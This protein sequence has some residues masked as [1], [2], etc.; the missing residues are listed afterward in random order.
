MEFDK[1]DVDIDYEIYLPR[2]A[3]IEVSNDFGDIIITDWNGKLE[4]LLRHGD[5]KI[6]EPVKS[7]KLN[8]SFGNINA[9]KIQAGTVDLKNGKLKV[10]EIE[11]LRLQSSGSELTLESVGFL[12]IKSIK[13]KCTSI[14]L[15]E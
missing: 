1:S 3:S 6:T 15:I 4:V 12:N 5:L 8:V 14:M 7:A 10:N 2:D 9:R 13:M 11:D